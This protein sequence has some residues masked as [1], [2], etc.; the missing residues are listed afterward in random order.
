MGCPP[1]GAPGCAA[2]G[3][4]PG[5]SGPRPPCGSCVHVLNHALPCQR[6]TAA[7]TCFE[8]ALISMPCHPVR[9]KAHLQVLWRAEEVREDGWSWSG[10]PRQCC[11]CD[12]HGL[13]IPRM[14]HLQRR[15]G[16]GEHFSRHFALLSRQGACPACAPPHCSSLGSAAGRRQQPGA[17]MRL[18]PPRTPS[19]SATV[20][21][22]SLQIRGDRLRAALLSWPIRQCSETD[23][24]Q[25]L[26][27]CST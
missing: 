27:T 23:G 3:S 11:R 14:H 15:Q 17:L 2:A 6:S 19:R 26:P 5:S 12:A 7:C 18:A 16:K 25:H 13:C 21:A 22:R 10:C 4:H 20:P 9:C 8:A 1:P 24:S